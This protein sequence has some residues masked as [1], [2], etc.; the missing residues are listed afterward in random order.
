MMGQNDE[1]ARAAGMMRIALQ[2]MVRN[3]PFHANLIA[4]GRVEESPMVETMAVTVRDGFIRFLYSPEFVC[5]CSFDELIGVLHHEVNHLLF[6]HLFADPDRYPD[7]E[8]WVIATEVTA[9]EFVPEP[10]PGEPLTLARFPELPAGEETETRYGKLARKKGGAHRK[11]I[12]SVLKSIAWGPKAGASAPKKVDSVQT[13][14]DHEI[15]AEARARGSLGK[16]IVRVGV[17]EASRGLSPGQWQK[18]PAA[19]RGRIDR[20]CRGSGAGSGVE[21]IGPSGRGGTIDWGQLLRQYVR[22]AVELRPVFNR[23]PRRFPELVGIV[24]GQVRRPGKARVLAVIDTSGSIANPMLGQISRELERMSRLYEIVVVECDAA[25]R[26]TYPYT[27]PIVRVRGRGGTD[28]R[29]P[30]RPGFLREVRPDVVVYFTDGFGPAP[31]KAPHVPLI[32]CLTPSGTRPAGW[33]RE[34]R[35]GGS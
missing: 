27:G 17:S 2:R 7:R 29:P 15:W 22:Q 23:P 4:Y 14:D 24:P 31:E 35:M 25:I 13:L 10:L 16:M 19:L 33:G 11:T 6:G 9:N 28:L 20:I 26:A 32:W 5:H 1:S 12:Q 21:N 18:V 3:Y 8:A 30:L 34:V